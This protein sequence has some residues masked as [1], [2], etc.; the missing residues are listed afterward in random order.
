VYDEHVI[1]LTLGCARAAAAHQVD[2]F[3]ELSTAQVYDGGKKASAEDSK[4]KPWTVLATKKL[5][6]EQGLE[7]VEGTY[8]CTYTLSLSSSLHRVVRHCRSPNSICVRKSINQ[9]ENVRTTDV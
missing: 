1:T 4:L 5:D 2:L 6:A 8:A 7:S 3:V 9:Q